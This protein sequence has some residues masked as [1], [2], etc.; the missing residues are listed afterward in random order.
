MVDLGMEISV[1]FWTQ[2]SLACFVVLP[3]AGLKC[4]CSYRMGQA[5]PFAFDISPALLRAVL[6]SVYSE[7]Q[8]ASSSSHFHTCPSALHKPLAVKWHRRRS[9]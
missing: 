6:S 9:F 5:L 2:D 1:I 4:S 3:V 8:N 7:F